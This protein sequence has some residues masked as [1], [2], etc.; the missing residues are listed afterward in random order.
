MCHS[1]FTLWTD[2]GNTI[3]LWSLHPMLVKSW[4]LNWT[5]SIRRYTKRF[6]IWRKKRPTVTRNWTK[7]TWLV[8]PVLCHWGMTT[9]LP[10]FSLSPRPSYHTVFW[11]LGNAQESNEAKPALTIGTAQVVLKTLSC[12]PESLQCGECCLFQGCKTV[13]LQTH[14]PLLANIMHTVCVVMLH[15]KFQPF[16]LFQSEDFV[17]KP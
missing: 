4:K 1:G 8:Q 10:A 13:L 7:D 6:L 15:C 2:L 14:N 11:Y 17:S 9:R 3:N 5:Y 12:I 16:D